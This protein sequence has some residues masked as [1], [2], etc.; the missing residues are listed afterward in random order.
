MTVIDPATPRRL[1]P[2]TTEESPRVRFGL[3]WTMVASIVVIWALSRL[4]GLAGFALA[5]HAQHQPADWTRLAARWDGE[6]YVMLA[7]NGYPST[8]D[9]PG[10]PFYGP[11]GFFPLWP[12]TIRLVTTL[13][14]GHLHAAAAIATAVCGLLALAAVWAAAHLVGGRGTAVAATLLMAFFPGSLA[15]TMPYTEGSFVLWS[16]VALLAL[17]VGGSGPLAAR[18]AFRTWPR[19]TVAIGA[20]AAF[21]ACGTRS[22]GVAVLAAVA[23]HAVLELRRTRRLPWRDVI[24]GASGVLG[25]VVDFV[26]AGI[27]TGDPFIWRRAQ[28]QWHQ[29]LDFGNGLIVDFSKT[30]PQHGPDYRADTVMLVMTGVLVVA[31]ALA[32]PSWRRIPFTW[33][34]YTVVMLALTLLWSSVGPRPRLLFALFPVFIAVA[35]TL[36]R[37]G[38]IGRV[39]IGILVVASAIASVGY[40]YAVFYVPWHVTA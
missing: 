10:R 11:W 12:W 1:V 19:A 7:G 24:I 29:V 21:L 30:I 25:F 2:E 37:W 36:L 26:Y 23:L 28:A 9:L 3:G 40:A 16:V 8:L 35:I 34:L 20:V 4:P 32:I 39:I 38:V 31:L 22:T 27:R 17:G 33:W 6:W 13:T 18:L 15:L 5:Q 14:G